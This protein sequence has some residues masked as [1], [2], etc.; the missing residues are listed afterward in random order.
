M[1]GELRVTD[2]A[3]R[4]IAPQRIAVG[5]QQVLF[6]IPSGKISKG[7]YHLHAHINSRRFIKQVLKE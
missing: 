3:G 7:V 6:I 2:M 5:E 4:L 1:A